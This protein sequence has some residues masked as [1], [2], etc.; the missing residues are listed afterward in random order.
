MFGFN[1]QILTL[2]I[3]SSLMFSMQSCMSDFQRRLIQEKG[4]WLICD[5]E[6]AEYK[7][8]R[9]DFYKFDYF[10][11]CWPYV[12]VQEYNE[13][14][15]DALPCEELANTWSYNAN[16][17]ELRLKSFDDGVYKIIEERGD[18][19]EVIEKSSNMRQYIIY[20]DTARFK[21]ERNKR[22]INYTN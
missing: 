21:H 1:K 18:T 7:K 2:A 19:I 22:E 14:W 8:F 9:L 10:G 15:P 5:T 16:L 11:K 6:E 13:F 20:V 4:L 12:Y 17:K 3:L